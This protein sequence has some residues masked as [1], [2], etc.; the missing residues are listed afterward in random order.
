MKIRH[1][2]PILFA[3]LFLTACFEEDQRVTPHEPGDE[4][5][6]LLKYNIYDTMQYFDCSSNQVVQ[7]FGNKEWNLGF[8]TAKKGW[9]ILLNS[10]P[11]YYISHTGSNDFDALTS[12]P[13]GYE[14]I[15]DKSNGD[16]DSTAIDKWVSFTETDT[17]YSNE[18]ILLGRYDGIN[19]SAVKKFVFT[20]VDEDKYEFRFAN[21]DGSEDVNF[22]IEKDTTVQYIYF[23]IA[24]G[25]SVVP[26]VAKTDWDLNF[27]QYSTMLY[28]DNGTPTP[29]SVR[30]VLI[31]PFG[32]E[33]AV[34]T[35]MTFAEITLPD[36]ENLHYSRQIDVIGHEWK[37][38]EGDVTKS[39]YVVNSNINY[40]IHDFAGFYY[41]LRFTKYDNNEGKK[42]YP[43]FEYQQL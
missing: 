38:F 42:G 40:F 16:R 9:Q 24:D 13:D 4:L 5:T 34:D 32:V 17:T 36:I 25:G 20:Y 43:V 27:C 37:S 30:G 29:Y 8:E 21:M 6:V 14:W 41:K 3:A 35:S 23:S 31:N 39:D 10:A 18:V 11:N 15:F 19:Y 1:I 22:S 2:L 28:D 12:T 33:V 7:E 26:Q